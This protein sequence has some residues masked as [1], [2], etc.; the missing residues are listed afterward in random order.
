MTILIVIAN[1]R[2][3]TNS[4][5]AK[6]EDDDFSGA[7]DTLSKPP[8][9]NSIQRH[10]FCELKVSDHFITNIVHKYNIYKYHF[11]GENHWKTH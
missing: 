3:R 9:Q 4:R 8:N 7:L 5:S 6:P 1:M 2:R 10:V 11:E